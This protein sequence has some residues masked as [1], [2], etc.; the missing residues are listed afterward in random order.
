MN[1][2]LGPVAESTVKTLESLIYELGHDELLPSERAL[3]AKFGVSRST[4]RVAIAHVEEKELLVKRGL[5]SRYTNISGQAASTSAFPTKEEASARIIFESALV[6]DVALILTDE[7]KASIGAFLERH[8]SSLLSAKQR[9]DAASILKEN[10]AFHDELCAFHPNQ[11][12]REILQLAMENKYTSMPQNLP[13]EIMITQHQLI[14]Q[15][16]VLGDRNLAHAAVKL[17]LAAELDCW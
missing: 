13:V 3:A 16:L 8:I 10:E 9:Q 14:I 2:R 17:N 12:A 15:A 5:T 4:L 11:R 6:G 1:A 7:Q